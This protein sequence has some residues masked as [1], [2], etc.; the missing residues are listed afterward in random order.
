MVG[1]LGKLIVQL[2]QV[3]KYLMFPFLAKADLRPLQSP[4]FKMAFPCQSFQG[5]GNS[6]PK[7][8]SYYKEGGGLKT[9][10]GLGAISFW[11]FALKLRLKTS[12]DFAAVCYF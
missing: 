9:T 4:A 12:I 6:L 2:C 11:E 1:K 8:V 7:M 3:K 10:F 5:Q